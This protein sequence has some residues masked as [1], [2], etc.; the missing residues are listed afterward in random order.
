MSLRD[1]LISVRTG[2]SLLGPNVTGDSPRIDSSSIE[3]TLRGAVIWLTPKS[4]EGYRP[5]DF[6]GILSATEN[7]D[8]RKSVEQFRRIASQVPGNKPATTR[9]IETQPRKTKK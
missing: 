9:Q 7:S 6:S 4:V 1:F 8:L 3:R 2:A 5:D